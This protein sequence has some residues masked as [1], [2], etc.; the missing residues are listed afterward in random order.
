MLKSEV[1]KE[2]ASAPKLLAGLAALQA[3]RRGWGSGDT[4]IRASLLP[5]EKGTP[6]EPR[7]L[8]PRFLRLPGK[9]ALGVALSYAGS[10]W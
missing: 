9:V 8:N 1:A 3:T 10:F 2:Q 5:S 4:K 6:P 7:D